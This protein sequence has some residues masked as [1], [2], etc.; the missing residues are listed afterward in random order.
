MARQMAALLRGAKVADVPVEQPTKFELAI[1]LKTA[2]ALGLTIAVPASRRRGAR[3][4]RV[5][6]RC[7]KTRMARIGRGQ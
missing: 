7:K 5:L 3:I 6:W 1:N 4:A 2:T